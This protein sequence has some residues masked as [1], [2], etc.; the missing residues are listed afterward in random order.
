M[1]T[2]VDSTAL[3]PDSGQLLAAL[4]QAAAAL[5]TDGKLAGPTSRQDGLGELV[6][7]PDALGVVTELSSGDY[8]VAVVMPSFFLSLGNDAEAVAALGAALG[9]TATALG[10]EIGEVV[11][12]D[13]PDELSS[14]L[15][16]A[17][18][19]VDAVVGAGIFDGDAVI[20]TVGAL[21]AISTTAAEAAPTPAP[22]RSANAG[23]S[24]R[25]AD[26][27]V[28]ERGLQLLADIELTVTAELGRARLA[29]GELLDLQPG[30]IVELDRE[31]GVPIDL[32]VNGTL[33]ARGEVVVVEDR[34]ALRVSEIVTDEDHG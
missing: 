1:T 15:E 24:F 30:A 25:S 11:R 14:R 22:S 19:T 3:D 7:G 5:A 18:F 20:A 2:S 23:S 26:S 17:G 16:A 21:L 10:V 8:L 32:L 31:A 34:F 6:P 13:R 33:F 27:A 29:V 28:M 4:D 12:F 9:K